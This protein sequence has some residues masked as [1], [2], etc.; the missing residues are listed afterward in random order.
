M[1]LTTPLHRCAGDWNTERDRPELHRAARRRGRTDTESDL[2]EL[3]YTRVYVGK[4]WGRAGWGDGDADGRR[5]R[6]ETLGESER[7]ATRRGR[8]CYITYAVITYKESW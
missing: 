7:R 3:S 4:A 8:R 2:S 6:A 1:F 5:C